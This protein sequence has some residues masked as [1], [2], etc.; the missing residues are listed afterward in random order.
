[1]KTAKRHGLHSGFIPLLLENETARNQEYFLLQGHVVK[2]KA[3]YDKLPPDDSWAWEHYFDGEYWKGRVQQ[4]EWKEVYKSIAQGDAKATVITS[5]G[6]DI[7]RP[8]SFWLR[9][10]RKNLS[11]ASVGRMAH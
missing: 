3:L 5:R 10:V 11:D 4:N 8:N 6:A 1:L 9:E 7:I 2:W